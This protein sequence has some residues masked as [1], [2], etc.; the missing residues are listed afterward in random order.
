MTQTRRPLYTA[1]VRCG[2]IA[3][4]MA[5]AGCV[6]HIDIQQGNLLEPDA[7]DQVQVGMSQSAVEYLLGTPTVADPFHA[8]RWDYPFYVKRSRSK[9]VQRTWVIVYFEGGRVSKIVRDAKLD[10]SS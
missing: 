8:N 10:S 4:C 1:A 3:A 2:L 6:Y 7:L 5:F 9:E